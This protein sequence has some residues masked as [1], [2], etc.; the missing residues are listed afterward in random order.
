MRH[1]FSKGWGA[2]QS[3]AQETHDELVADQEFRAYG[4]GNL[5]AG[6][7]GGIAIAGSMS[8]SEAARAAGAKSQMANIIQQ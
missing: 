4:I 6:L 5:G 3:L 8:K 7:L 2:S 1:T